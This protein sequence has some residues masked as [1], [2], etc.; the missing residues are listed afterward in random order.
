MVERLVQKKEE[1]SPVS[2][3]PSADDITRHFGLAPHPEG[4]FLR[5]RI[6]RLR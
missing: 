3:S 5:R 4:G 2:A 6:V 1:V